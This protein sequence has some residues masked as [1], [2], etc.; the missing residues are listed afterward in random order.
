MRRS[1]TRAALC[2]RINKIGT[3]SSRD[4]MCCEEDRGHDRCCEGDRRE[5]HHHHH[6][7]FVIIIKLIGVFKMIAMLTLTTCLH[8]CVEAS[9]P[10]PPPPS[11][12]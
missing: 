7:I 2:D 11:P 8:G 3:S 4:V 5:D 9:L 6:Q 12:S 1:E 10:S